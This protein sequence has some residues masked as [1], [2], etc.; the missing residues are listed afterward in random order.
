MVEG[1]WKKWEMSSKGLI[2]IYIGGTLNRFMVLVLKF[3]SIWFQRNAMKWIENQFDHEPILLT[4]LDGINQ[5]I[6]LKRKFS[7]LNWFV[8]WIED[9]QMHEVFEKT[10]LASIHK[11]IHKIRI[12]S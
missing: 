12:D 1:F 11:L 5:W 2:Y 8:N 4:V 3:D 10:D 6:N 7:I 9:E